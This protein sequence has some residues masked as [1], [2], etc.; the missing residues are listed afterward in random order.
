LLW[1]DVNIR[2]PYFKKGFSNISTSTAATVISV[3]LLWKYGLSGWWFGLIMMWIV[4]ATVRWIVEQPLNFCMS[5][6]PEE[7]LLEEPP[8]L[9]PPMDL[10]PSQEP[11][12]SLLE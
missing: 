9:L 2:S 1:W 11:P 8:R 10:P 3:Y 5:T 7:A 4:I 6:P 12:R